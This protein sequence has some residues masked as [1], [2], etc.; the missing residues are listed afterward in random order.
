MAAPQDTPTV[1]IPDGPWPFGIDSVSD[2]L[3]VPRGYVRWATNALNKGG[4]WKTRPA[5]SIL[6]D[7]TNGEPR[8]LAMFYP[9]N[10]RPTL[11][12]AVGLSAVRVS[13]YPF[14]TWSTLTGDSFSPTN[15]PV[16]MTNC[17]MGAE[18]QAD[19][20]L[21]LLDSFPILIMQDGLSRAWSWDGSARV[22]LDPDPD[23]LAQ[24]PIGRFGIWA[25]NRYWVAQ[26]T[27]LYASNILEPTKFT[28]SLGIANGGWFTLPG[29][30]TGMG[31]TAD[32]KSL[33]V[34]TST[35]TT[36]FQVTLPRD[37]WTATPGFQQEILP[38]IGC[39]AHRSIINQ[40][41]MLWWYS[42]GGWINLDEAL[43][44]YQSSRVHYKDNNMMLGKANM[45]DDKSAICAG[46][47]DNYTM[48]STPSGDIYNAHTWVMDQMPSESDAETLNPAWASNWT[49]IR[50]VQW[51]TADVEGKSRVF[52]L[53]SDKLTANTHVG[54]VW[55]AFTK[56]PV[57]VGVNSGEPTYVPIPVSFHTRYLTDGQAT[58]KSFRY[59]RA[60]VS[61]L[62]GVV[63]HGWS[64]ASR[65]GAF[66]GVLSKQTVATTGSID[67]RTEDI[68]FRSFVFFPQVRELR[69]QENIAKEADGDLQQVEVDRT[70]N[71]D[72]GFFLE[73]NWVGQAAYNELSL[74]AQPHGDKAR[75]RAEESE[76][77]DRYTTFDGASEILETTPVTP[78]EDNIPQ[79]AL[80]SATVQSVSARFREPQY[81]IL[82]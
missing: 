61:E 36:A 52:V 63:I 15:A 23:G 67:A 76:Q 40:Y 32:E 28:E 29:E 12:K 42:R 41:G 45:S 39:I 14:T 22:Q 75:G 20:S 82:E 19:G 9:K 10:G 55:E 68:G 26:G 71:R 8:G 5:F 72:R 25:G 58:I 31:K 69:S 27:R 4:H 7:G 11:V 66:K 64:Y 37:L 57:D 46:A 50:P 18:T 2:P 17:I 21:K 44:S 49:G 35:T 59:I 24:T 33:L 54:Q 6:N 51:V 34:F 73:I 30:I 65:H 80:E 81:N 16:Y 13:P 47:F 56:S 43:R 1:D 38:N 60:L 74:Y 48:L 77:T 62:T 53:S 78:G 79:S 3:R 70:R